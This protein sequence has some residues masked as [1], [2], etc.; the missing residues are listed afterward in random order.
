MSAMMKVSMVALTIILTL[1]VASIT[2]VVAQAGYEA[3]FLHGVASGDPVSDAIVIW[4][5]ATPRMSV[6][7]LSVSWQ[8]RTY[9]GGEVIDSGTV[10]T[11]GDRDWTVKVDVQ[12]PRFRYGL[13][14]E[15]QFSVG[16]QDSPV[17]LFSLPA[18]R[19]TPQEQLRYAVFSCSYWGGYFNAYV[20]SRLKARITAYKLLHEAPTHHF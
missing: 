13:R 14:Y 19:G 5:R 12:S 15:Y 1:I 8:V 18:P 3:S 10:Q 4:T 2:T 9:G 17:G 7:S 11:N 6:D 16:I 20:L